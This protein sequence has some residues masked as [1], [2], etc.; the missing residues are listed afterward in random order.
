LRVKSLTP[1][2][3]TLS[4]DNARSIGIEAAIIIIAVSAI[5]RTVSCTE[6]PAEVLVRYSWS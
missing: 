2:G 1:P 4:R 3:P 5:D 6:L